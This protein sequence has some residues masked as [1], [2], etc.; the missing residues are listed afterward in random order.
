MAQV[1][2]ENVG[3]DLRGRHRGREEPDARDPRRRADG[4]RRAVGV[5]EDDRAAHG[6][7]PRGDLVRRR[8]DRRRRGERLPPRERDVAMVFQNYALYPHKT[9]YENL[10]FPLKL[11]GLGKSEIERAREA[12]RRD[13]RAGGAASAAPAPALGWPA[14]AG[15]DGAG[16]DPRAAGLPDG[17]AALEPRREAP[18]ADARGD[19]RSC[20]RRS[21]SRRSTS[22]T[23]RSRR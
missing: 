22:R 2:F 15:R 17:R 16:D 6:G 11:R 5:R 12:H 19:Q 14:A 7:G 20:T 4:A 9:I 23:T 10:S 1:Q 13:P 18:H 8:P 21:E 3:Q